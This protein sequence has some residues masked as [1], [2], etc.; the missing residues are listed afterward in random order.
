MNA[1][2]DIAVVTLLLGTVM[3]SAGWLVARFV[4]NVVSVPT[5]E[6]AITHDATLDSTTRRRCSAH[7]SSV[8]TL[9]NLSRT[10]KFSDLTFILRLPVD[11][12]GKFTYK[13]MRPIPPSYVPLTQPPESTEH[14]ITYPPAALHP[15]TALK[16][17]AC[18]SG[19]QKPTFHIAPDG[20]A[21]RPVA[22]GLLTALIRN[23]LFVFSALFVI[24]TVFVCI[25]TYRGFAKEVGED[26]ATP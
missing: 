23:E 8:I 3:A 25:V 22:K 21:V 9:H 20:D 1:R 12:A 15:G 14:A 18:Y 16:L 13:D 10:E 24:W 26:H 2:I 7:S 6:Y 19:E 5:I 4:Q 17:V 11:K